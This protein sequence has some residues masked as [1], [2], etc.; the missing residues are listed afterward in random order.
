MGQTGNMT[1]QFKAYHPSPSLIL[2]QAKEMQNNRR[3]Q[4]KELSSLSLA[5]IVSDLNH[6]SENVTSVLKSKNCTFYKSFFFFICWITVLCIP[7]SYFDMK[8]QVFVH[9][10]DVV[11]DV[12]HYP[13]DD[14]H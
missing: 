7:S 3:L 8:L 11:E 6:I 2:S 5:L 14:S 13:G 4:K 1:L 10:I 12:L 9:G